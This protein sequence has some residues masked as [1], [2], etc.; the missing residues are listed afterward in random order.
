MY[1][2]KKK[3]FDSKCPLWI[4]YG[5]VSREFSQE[6]SLIIIKDLLS[7]SRGADKFSRKTYGYFDTVRLFEKKIIWSKGTL[8]L[9]KQFLTWK[10][11]FAT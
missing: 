10:Q 8:S 2:V 3:R 1:S 5:T 6:L 7:R 9:I 4:L 11:R